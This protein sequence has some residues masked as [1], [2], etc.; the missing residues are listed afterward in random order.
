MSGSGSCSELAAKVAAAL[1]DQGAT[2]LEAKIGSYIASF[3]DT[4]WQTDRK[5]SKAIPKDRWGAHYHRESIGRARRMLTRAG[6]LH[7]KRIMP[8]VVPPGADY[9][10][11]H[12]TTSKGIRWK[13]VGVTRP[14]KSERRA[15]AAQAKAVERHE[16]LAR[17]RHAAPGAI[18]PE[19]IGYRAPR[20]PKPDPELASVL[21][22]FESLQQSARARR[23]VGNETQPTPRQGPDPPD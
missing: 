13:A 11:P 7:V 17:S 3:G 2:N 23:G 4:N 1:L 19:T 8:G 5:L 18:N 15:M 16:R 9:P 14:P 12:G 10:A 22:D 6:F 21:A 20:S